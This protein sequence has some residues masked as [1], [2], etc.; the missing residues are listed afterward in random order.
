[1]DRDNSKSNDLSALRD[2]LKRLND[3]IERIESALQEKGTWKGQSIDSVTDSDGTAINQQLIRGKDDDSIEFRIGQ[4]G[5]A[6]LGNIVLLFGISFLVQYLHRS[7]YPILSPLIGYIS[8]AAIY[9]VGYLS[10]AAYSYL[11]KLFVYTGHLLLIYVT[12]RL[13]FASTEP[14]IGSQ[15]A[16]IAIL[17]IVLTGLFALAYRQKSQTMAGMVLLMLL[18]SGIMS[19]SIS[20]I[21]VMT[22]IAALVSV[23]LYYRFGWIKLAF[24]FILLTYLSHLNWLLN[25]P[26]LGNNPEFIPSLGSGY[27]YFLASGLIFSMLA[28]IPQKENISDDFIISSVVWNG[29][30]FSFVLALIIVTWLS[31][32]FVPVFAAIA[33]LCIAYSIILQAKSSLKITASM[34]A[35]Y[36][37]MAMSVAFYGILLFPKAYMLLALQSLLVVSMALW[38]R[39]RFIVVMNTILFAGLLILYLAGQDISSPTNFSFMVVAF[40]TA[41]IINWK[42]ERLNI[43]TELIRNLYLS[44]GF[45]M[46][47]VAFYHA[48]PVS[49][50]TVSWM[51]AAILFFAVSRILRNIKYRWLAIGALLASAIKLILF[52]LSEISIGIR[53]LMFLFLAIISITVSIIYTKFSAKKKE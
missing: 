41:R 31:K 8:V 27:I 19:N 25:N 1:M 17:L 49:L 6:W 26:L 38:F 43:K 39:S 46:T 10:R 15:I 3:R 12:L 35:L 33:V 14:L 21:P 34:Y 30:N 42:K 51:I 18:I 52:D 9:A 48:F 13:H 5:M 40:I 44:G 16:G 4:Y 24:I 7:G 53:V 45:T 29:I 37:F 36:G 23:I 22:S 50:I 11:S 47:L 20:F 28:I 2:E 32:N